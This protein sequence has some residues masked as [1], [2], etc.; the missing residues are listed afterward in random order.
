MCSQ[1]Q[2]AEVSCVL[3]LLLRR[4][5]KYQHFVSN[6]VGEILTSFS[7]DL[8]GPSEVTLNK[9]RQTVISEDPDNSY[10]P[11][12]RKKRL[13]GK[14]THAKVRPV[15]SLNILLYVNRQVRGPRK[16]YTIPSVQNMSHDS[17]S[18]A[19]PFIFVSDR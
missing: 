8:N 4:I 6:C 18:F 9:I 17:I 1:E 15:K 13:L 12:C 14:I 7:S 16:P 10:Y 11:G 19:Y 3:L 5:S 2:T